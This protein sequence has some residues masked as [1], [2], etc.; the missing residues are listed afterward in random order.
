MTEIDVIHNSKRGIKKS[1]G[2]YNIDVRL[3][4]YSGVGNGMCVLY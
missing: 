2:T 4:G 3:N 1:R